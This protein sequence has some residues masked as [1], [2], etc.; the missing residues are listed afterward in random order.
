MYSMRAQLIAC[1][2][3]RNHVILS[4]F[5]DQLPSQQILLLLLPLILAEAAQDLYVLHSSVLFLEQ[6]HDKG[7]NII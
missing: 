1:F 6:S 4:H 3:L 5:I 7:S 2:T